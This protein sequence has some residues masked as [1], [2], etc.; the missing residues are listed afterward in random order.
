VV[1]EKQVG[2]TAPGLAIQNVPDTPPGGFE[3][4]PAKVTP[5]QGQADQAKQA[6]PPPE[7]LASL[8]K[9]LQNRRQVSE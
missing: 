7:D 2:A 1:P 5:S 4:I 8:G 6:T 3:P 9:A